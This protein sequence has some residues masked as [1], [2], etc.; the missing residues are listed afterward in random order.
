MSRKRIH[1]RKKRSPIRTSMYIPPGSSATDPMPGETISRP[2]NAVAVK[3]IGEQ[4]N[5]YDPDQQQALFKQRQREAEKRQ[6]QIMHA[7]NA[8]RGKGGDG[9]HTHR[10]RDSGLGGIIQSVGRGKGGQT[11]SPL[12]HKKKY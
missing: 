2:A 8:G 11:Q 1:G 7:Y 5:N 12:Y 4:Q 9:A 10:E 6:Q 3:P